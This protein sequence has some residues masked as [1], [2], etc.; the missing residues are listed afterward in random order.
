M[1]EGYTAQ[2][3]HLQQVATGINQTIGELKTLGI[4]EEAEQ[5]RGFSHMEMTGMQVGHEQLRQS[6]ANF[7]ER[8][9]WGVR[10]LVSDGNQLA[11][12]LNLS[13]GAYYEGDQYAAGVFKDLL[14]AFVG[15]PHASEQQV[16][17]ETVGQMLHRDL[18]D[19]SSG[20]FAQAAD[21]AAQTWN[22]VGRDEMEGPMGLNRAAADYLGLGDQLTAAENQAYPL[23][24]PTDHAGSTNH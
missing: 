15:D 23:H 7:C 11:V 10:S 4:A 24:T 20:S 17:N 6:F 18:P 3:Q 13:A 9:S 8:W 12:R 14:N 16:E 2:A 19:Y 5:G 1:G 21:N 22:G